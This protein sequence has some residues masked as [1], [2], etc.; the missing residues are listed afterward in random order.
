VRKGNSRWIPECLSSF[1]F[2][3]DR[4]EQKGFDLA[5]RAG[6]VISGK[7]PFVFLLDF[8]G[9]EGATVFLMVGGATYGSPL[10]AD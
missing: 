6:R 1:A 7:L 8:P 5:L 10:A 4:F 2:N 9:S 3:F